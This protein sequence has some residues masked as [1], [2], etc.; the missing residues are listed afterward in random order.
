M[1]GFEMDVKVE[2]VVVFGGEGGEVVMYE[3]F[4]GLGGGFGFY[5]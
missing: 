2:R 4:W 5:L 1:F 3:G